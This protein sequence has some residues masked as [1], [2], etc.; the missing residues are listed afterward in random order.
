MQLLPARWVRQI[1]LALVLA[2]TTAGSAAAVQPA[3]PSDL[4]SRGD[5]RV[6]ERDVEASNAKI[7][8]A[9]GALI[10]MWSAEF[11]ALGQR[12]APPGLARYRGAV[13]TECGVMPGNN[14]LYCP[15]RNTIY[16][17]EVF[18]A[19]QTRNAARDL[20]TDGD[21]V[22]VGIIAHE[23]GHAVAAQLGE[24]SRVPYENEAT[25]DCLAGAFTQRAQRD[26]TLEKG[27]LEE[28][29]YG[30]AAAGD[31]TPQPTGD[32]RYDARVVRMVQLMGHGSRQQ[33]MSNFRT[34]LDGG[35]GA[36]LESFR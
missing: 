8:D 2:L 15:S 11:R 19:R 7:R 34:G 1:G 4:T 13:R 5:V 9:Y 32:R 22:A 25:A 14:A 33:R 26:G 17:D 20:G 10:D 3:V 35:P 24:D 28:A 27:D 31:P 21:M 30:M 16:F 12:F 36:C 6:T 23:M 18:I 29:F